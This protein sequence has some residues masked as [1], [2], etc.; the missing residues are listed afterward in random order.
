[1]EVKSWRIRDMEGVMHTVEVTA[2]TLYETV[3]V[4]ANNVQVEHTLKIGEFRKWMERNGKSPTEMAR[5]RK[6]REIFG[7]P[8]GSAGR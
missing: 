4:C 1:M 7:M 5:I 8:G 2:S 6:V 3:T